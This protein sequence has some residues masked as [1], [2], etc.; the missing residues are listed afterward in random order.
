M[1]GSF[2]SNINAIASNMELVESLNLKLSELSSVKEVLAFINS[3]IDL[4]D[5]SLDLAKGN[6]LGKRQI[7]INADGDSLIKKIEFN[8]ESGAVVPFVIDNT[9]T[10]ADIV[11]TIKLDSAYISQVNNANV[12]TVTA[13]T[14]TF[15]IYDLDGLVSNIH[16]VTIT[17]VD[18]SVLTTT[19]S[20]TTSSLQ[21]IIGNSKAF[22][23]IGESLSTIKAL[24]LIKDVLLAVND[25]EANINIV[26]SRADSIDEVSQNIVAVQNSSENATI[27]S[28]SAQTAKGYRD[29]LVGLSVVSLSLTSDQSASA[30]YDSSLGKLTI[31]IPKGLKGD[32][33]DP[34]NVNAQG[35]I[36]QRSSYD[37]Q[38]SG[39]SFLSLD[40]DMIYFRVGDTA[41]AWSSGSP[42][43]KGDKGDIGVGITD[44]SKTST[45]GLVDTYTITYADTTTSTFN[46][47][48]GQDGGVLSVAG[49]SG[50]VTLTISDIATLEAELNNRYTKAQTDAKIDEKIALIDFSS[51][52]VN[53][54]IL[55]LGN[56]AIEGEALLIIKSNFSV[57]LED[58]IVSDGCSVVMINEE[59]TVTDPTVANPSFTIRSS[60]PDWLDS[61][62]NIITKNLTTKLAKPT[63][64]SPDNTL[65]HTD[66]TYTIGNLKVTST[67]IIFDIQS[68]DF[69]IVSASSGSALKVG[70]TIE[71]TGY[72]GASLDLV[73]QYSAEA[74]YNNRCKVQAAN[75]T[76]SAYSDIDSINTLSISVSTEIALYVGN[77]SLQTV[78]LIDVN[79][80]IGKLVMLKERNNARAWRWY[81]SLRGA[82]KLLD[83]SATSAEQLDAD[84]LVAFNTDGF[85]LGA[86]SSTNGGGN[87][88]VAFIFDFHTHNPTNNDGSIQSNVMNNDY[89]SIGSYESTGAGV[90]TIGHGLITKP[91]LFIEKAKEKIGSWWTYHEA[92]G[93][94][95]YLRLNLTDAEVTNSG[96]WN[97]TEP[98]NNIV[99]IGT[100]I[101]D[102]SDSRVFYAFTSVLGKCKVGSYSG[103]GASGNAIDCGFTT[104]T[105]WLMVKK[106]NGAGEWL[107]FD[108]KRPL[109]G[110]GVAVSL[111]INNTIAE[112]TYATL[113]M[114][115]AATGFIVG[116]T[117][118]YVN[119]LGGSYIFVAIAVGA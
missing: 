104:G 76:D 64:S 102:T 70:N 23:D 114:E 25:N 29:E 49:R 112:R 26:S 53:D 86:D 20:D 77:A 38:S 110:L 115:F 71:I 15:I 44:I 3:A 50:D 1:N 83:S 10:S 28:N 7:K 88:Y 67:K 6:Y 74:T 27:A 111:A 113:S 96:L 93:A 51:T 103:T 18:E 48:N 40:E 14:T 79:N 101:N 12:T 39:F 117:E 9:N 16:S 69:I 92:I 66:V 58:V 36:A 37:A 52:R 22:I 65:P 90:I 106:A 46:I 57:D 107:I 81:D 119:A 100:G 78:T 19:W 62:S 34:F 11:A 47:T 2:V 95:K 13:D 43:G 116:S 41:G 31:G 109:G 73:L 33:G 17:R 84:G 63:L 4:G 30:S 105:Q 59:I 8:L 21:N 91:Q 55:T 108:N 89:M 99:T 85:D 68:A 87:S 54:P 94:T 45:V 35:T 24:N 82:T 56:L 98:D 32:K 72:S 75:Y 5:V 97:D 80:N 61:E 60:H 42:F 118:N